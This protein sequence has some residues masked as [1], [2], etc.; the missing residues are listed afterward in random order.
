MA[1]SSVPA[2]RSFSTESIGKKGK[3]DGRREGASSGLSMNEVRAKAGGG[4]GLKIVNA[5][6]AVK[7]RLLS[8][9]L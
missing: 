4:C 9:S 8:P 1:M 7:L 6:D 3:G 5:P 2:T